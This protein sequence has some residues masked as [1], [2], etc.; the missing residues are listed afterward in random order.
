[1]SVKLSRLYGMDIYSDG[2]KYLGRVQD[3]ILDLEKGEILRI[4]LEPLSSVT[5]EDAKKILREKSVLY[6]NVKSVEDVVMVSGRPGGRTSGE[7][8]EELPTH[9]GPPSFFARG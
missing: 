5:R 9:S 1:M 7:E 2:G 6:K 3:L 4:T 8:A